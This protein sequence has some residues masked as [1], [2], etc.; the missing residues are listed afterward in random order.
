MHEVMDRSGRVADAQ[1][2]AVSDSTM[3]PDFAPSA[4]KAAA[5]PDYRNV[6]RSKPRSTNRSSVRAWRRWFPA[7]AALLGGG[8]F[9]A[10]TDGGRE[11]RDLVSATTAIDAMAARFGFGI[12]QIELTGY[13][14][15][16]PQRALDIIGAKGEQSILGLGQKATLEALVQLP[17]VQSA[18]IK[19]IWP[20]RLQIAIVEREAFAV[21]HPHRRRQDAHLIDRD[22]TVLVPV[23][24]DQAGPLPRI[25]GADAPKNVAPLF[26]QLAKLPDLVAKTDYLEFVGRRRWT[27]H[28]THGR[29]V[30]LP[31]RGLSLAL[32]QLAEDAWLSRISAGETIDFRVAN[33]VTVGRSPILQRPEDAEKRAVSREG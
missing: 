14:Q 33:Q 6:R 8:V 21:W 24:A 4:S 20:D 19:R 31:E 32:T 30:L 13:R 1:E 5:T 12:R 17:W 3:R 9:L 18:E 27:L 28:L 29:R 23:I 15:T 22:G 16:N 10:A 2:A 26:R 25:I 7:V 11:S